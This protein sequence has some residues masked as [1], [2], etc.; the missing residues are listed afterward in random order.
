MGGIITVDIH[1]QQNNIIIDITDQGPGV[2]DY[3]GERVFE[4]FFSLPR[5]DTGQKSTGLG[6]NFARE[7]A[8]L[9]HGRLLLENR[10]PGTRAR[11]IL[12]VG[13]R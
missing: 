11:L 9:H 13:N 3:V 12:P 5:P 8:E 10:N 2:P 4:R 7:V 6:L 1:P